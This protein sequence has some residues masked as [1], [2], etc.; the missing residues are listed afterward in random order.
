MKNIRRILILAFAFMTFGLGAQIDYVS[1]QVKSSY[2]GSFGT[3]HTKLVSMIPNYTPVTDGTDDC[4]RYGTNRYLCTDSTGFFYVKK[5]DGRWW[6]V[7]PNGYAG[8]NM[9]VTSFSSSNIQNDYDLVKNL[10]FNGTGNFLSSDGQTYTSYNP[11]NYN[12]FSYTRALN[13]FLSYKNVRYTANYYPNTP[14]IAQKSVDYLT[15]FDPKFVTFC[16]QTAKSIA[17]PAANERDLLGYFTDNELNFNTDQ[18]QN[19]VRDLPAGDPSRDSAMV[20]ASSK[21][22]TVADVTTPT[23]KLTDAIKQGFAALLA[24]KYYKTVSE[25]IHKYDKNHLIIGSRLHGTPRSIQAVVNASQKYMDVTSVNF[26]DKYSPSDQIAT[27]SWTNDK[28][29]LVTEFYIKDI[30]TFS[31]TQSGAGWYVNSQT[32]R[33][34]WYQN[35]CIDLLKNKCYIGWQY[36]RYQDDTDSNKGIVDGSGV[37]YTE[38][39][40][41]MKE[42]NKQIYHLCEFY[43][44]NSRR[45]SPNYK[46]KIFTA[47][48][49]AYVIPGTTSTTNYGSATELEVRGNSREAS[50]RE[51]FFKFDLSSLKDS[52]KYLKHAQLDLYC[53]QSDATARTVFV[54]GIVDNS[55]QERTLN[56]ALRNAN[57]N[58]SNNL[59]RLG[60]Q[61][62][63]V[64]VGNLT[65]DVTSWVNDKTTNGLVTFKMQDLTYTNTAIKVAS[66]ENVNQAYQPKLTLSFYDMTS[67]G[68]KPIQINETKYRLFPNPSTSFVTVEGNNVAEVNFMT[69]SGQFVSHSNANKIDVS[70]FPKGIYLVNVKSIDGKVALLKFVK[71]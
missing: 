48:E 52:L 25:A 2:A 45:P 43:D 9:A 22:L 27:N 66:K 53:T 6:M 29:C 51:A 10:G 67:A 12:L 36:F 5:I 54:S 30:N 41:F 59:N 42:L 50:V 19:L 58:W 3:Q 35:T 26:Y 68:I 57:T 13:F 38:M 28:P 21:G 71:N 7:D 11:N 17:Q 4:T 24:T 60:S 39:T 65:Y 37:E 40:T 14:V 23:S 69:T 63:V 8:I 62:S 1:I 47:T 64:D 18:L 61:K 16:D 55:W 56:G 15:V 33:G 32:M 31:A 20:Y 34:D 44:S 70:A 49:D 46:S